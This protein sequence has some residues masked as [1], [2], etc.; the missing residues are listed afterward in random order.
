MNKTIYKDSEH[1]NHGGAL[2]DV[3]ITEAYLDLL[4]LRNRD[5]VSANFTG[6]LGVVYVV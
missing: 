1:Q 2:L 3:Q 5:Q 6:S 4:N